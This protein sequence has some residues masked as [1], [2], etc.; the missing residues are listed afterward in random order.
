MVDIYFQKN[1]YVL[2]SPT[3]LY[4]FAQNNEKFDAKMW[5]WFLV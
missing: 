2:I 4:T 3:K 1:R 5:C